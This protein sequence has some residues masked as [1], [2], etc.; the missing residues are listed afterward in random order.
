MTVT[1]SPLDAAK[2][3]LARGFVVFPSDHPEQRNCIGLH[4]PTT[5]CD[6]ERG[7]HPAVKWGT[8]RVVTDK[9]LDI[10]W[11]RR[12]GLANPAVN[13]GP[14]NLVVFDEDAAGELLRW[15]ATYGVTLPEDTYTV[16]TGKGRHLYYQWDHTAERIGNCDKVVDGFK[17][18]IRGDGGN[19]LGAGAQHASGAV[20][21]GNDL[22]VA[23]LPAEVA[24]I[25]LASQNGKTKPAPPGA[26]SAWETFTATADPNTAKIP[27]GQRHKTLIAYAGRLL[28][29]GLDYTE[30][31]P[32]FHQRWLL[33]EQPEGQIPEAKFHSP[34]CPSPV[35]W[36]DAKSKLADVYE[37]YPA[38][39]P[40]GEEPP[41]PFTFTDGGAFIFD[42]PGTIPAIWG[43]GTNVLWA[44][45][46][47]LMIAGPMGLGKTTLGGQLTKAR[48]GLGDGYVLGLP[49]KDSG[50]IVLY[51]AMD[52]PRQIARSLARQF[53]PEDRHT[54]AA[55]LKIWQGPPPADIAQNPVLL[56]KLAQE[57]GA[58]TVIIDSVKDAATGLSNDEVGA[59]YNR[60]RQHLVAA[61][62]DLL[63]LHHTVKRGAAG[64]APTAAAD[65]YG[66][67]WI[68]NGTGS[69]IM[70]SGDPG[71]PV[72]G[73]KHIRQPAEEVGPFE[74]HHDQQRGRLT[75]GEAFS[76]I[77][78]V[79][80]CGPEGATAA[81]LAEAID[82]DIASAD[83]RERNSAREKAR[84]KLDK[85]VESGRLTKVEGEK[86][87]GGDR[88]LPATYFE[89][90]HPDDE[91]GSNHAPITHFAKPLVE[92]SRTEAITH[93]IT[94][95]SRQS[96]K[97]EKPQVKQSRTQSRTRPAHAITKP[98]VPEGDRGVSVIAGSA[99]PP[100]LHCDK[101][102]IGKQR[103]K[104]DR[105][106]HYTCQPNTEG[107]L[108]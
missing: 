58:D 42:Q 1:T 47:S 16:T 69:I 2:Q 80:S 102:V 103:D 99:D 3:L 37:R 98:T 81:A 13:C 70:L 84:R 73:F 90:A 56:L 94:Q 49:V 72:V 75:I 63:E 23:P 89:S 4:G 12:G 96:R 21:T 34:E 64:G 65:V 43:T 108:Q 44:E 5:P 27:A 20:Y 46:E 93:P 105:P 8:W 66:S 68:A 88:R 35:E 28:S 33:C 50:G 24:A 41:A 14:S 85:L 38:G 10:N 6:G 22:D 48:L 17:M 104:Y 107:T 54:V 52:R 25:L 53:R 83:K 7:K 77:G 71:D 31:V 39:Q 57:A 76:V 29:K 106:A 60:A 40:G 32:V 61:G 82:P 87:G 11:R 100:C 9:M 78:F 79:A 45:G 59:G 30:A 86:G 67:A 51:L 92:Q 26:A 15:C 36:D 55:R 62:I 91:P 95:Q 101:P 19:V 97:S 74:L 18:D